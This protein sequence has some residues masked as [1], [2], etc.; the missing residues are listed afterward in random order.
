MSNVSV[1]ADDTQPTI[2]TLIN[3]DGLVWTMVTNSIMLAV[4]RFDLMP[5]GVCY[6]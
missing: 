3:S 1:V 6:L 5:L 4:F 2:C